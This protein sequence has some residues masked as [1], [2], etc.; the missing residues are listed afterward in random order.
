MRTTT[1]PEGRYTPTTPSQLVTHP[2]LSHEAARILES[3]REPFT[4]EN[5]INTMRSSRTGIKDIAVPYLTDTD[6]WFLLSV[7]SQH[8]L[9]FYKRMGLTFSRGTD[10]QTKDALYDGMYRASVT[11]DEWRG[12]YGSAP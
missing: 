3:D 10:S 5:Q 11:F 7:K 6:A 4:D 2:E 8:T 12:T 1:S 9:T